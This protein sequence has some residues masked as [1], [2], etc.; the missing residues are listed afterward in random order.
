MMSGALAGLAGV[1]PGSGFM[2]PV[3]SFCLGFVV[4]AAAFFYARWMKM[5]GQEDVLDVTS[6]QAIPGIIG[7]LATGFLAEKSYSGFVDGVFFGGDGELLLWQFIALVVIIP[8]TAFWTFA[9][10]LFLDYTI[11]VNISAEVEHEGLDM[12]EHGEQA[13]I[14]GQEHD[15]EVDKA[16][17]IVGSN[18]CDAAARGDLELVQQ[19]LKKNV[20]ANITDYDGRTPFHLAAAEGHI[21]ILKVLSKQKGVDINHEDKFGSTPLQDAIRNRQH[22]VVMWLR[23]KGAKVNDNLST[24]LL[25]EAAADGEVSQVLALLTSGV[26]PN[27]ADYDGRTPLHI[28]VCAGNIEV[29]KLLLEHNAD[30]KAT[31]RWGSTPVDDAQRYKLTDIQSLLTGEPVPLNDDGTPAAVPAEK[32]YGGMARSTQELCAASSAGD[33]NEVRRLIKKEANP[34]FGDY[35]GRTPLHLAAAGGHM[36]IVK[37]LCTHKSVNVNAMDR[38]HVTPYHE[39]VKN[40]HT[41]VAEWLHSHGGSI[42]N[43][44]VAYRLCEAAARGD[45]SSLQKFKSEGYSLGT[46]DYDARTPLHLACAEGHIEIVR[47]LLREPDIDVNVRDRWGGTPLQDAM[48]RKQTEV[49]ELLKQYGAMESFAALNEDSEAQFAEMQ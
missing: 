22:H 2:G 43:Q 11:G 7:S 31:D 23:K 16:L 40:G 15:E 36:K 47:Y 44:K 45:L 9:L 12:A 46:A 27:S 28:A 4:G 6:L 48:R 24:R 41:E 34:G 29:V 20:P 32:A 42:I 30:I 35:D 39:A 8:W 10:L 38:W 18:L 14:L 13:Y 1:T 33:V 5:K 19:Y 26:S 21:Q 17:D 3:A 49:V 25:C 37:Y